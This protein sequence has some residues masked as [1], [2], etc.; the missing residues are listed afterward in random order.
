MLWHNVLI[1]V[2]HSNSDHLVNRVPTLPEN[3]G[4]KVRRKG[5]FSNH[6]MPLNFAIM[7]SWENKGNLPPLLDGK[8]CITEL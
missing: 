8:N 3:W 7:E 1:S 6:E 4:E 2:L 5:F